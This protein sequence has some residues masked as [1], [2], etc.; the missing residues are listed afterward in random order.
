MICLVASRQ[1]E[2]INSLPHKHTTVLQKCIAG[3]DH[4]E[5]MLG[6]PL[7]RELEDVTLVHCLPARKPWA[8]CKM[9]HVGVWRAGP[10]FACLLCP[11]ISVHV[12][13][14]VFSKYDFINRGQFPHLR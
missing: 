10:H 5:A 8:V 12:E 4:P 7:S 9:V 14:A 1:K 2:K 13:H 3:G 6:A 11:V